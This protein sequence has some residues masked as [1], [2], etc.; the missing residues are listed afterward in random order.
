M[1]AP[2]A[3]REPRGAFF[4]PSLHA[5]RVVRY[6]C[7]ITPLAG[8]R[9]AHPAFRQSAD[10]KLTVPASLGPQQTSMTVIAAASGPRLHYPERRRQCDPLRRGVALK[11]PL[12]SRAYRRML[13]RRQIRQ[14][15]RQR[16]EQ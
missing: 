15:A 9:S 2:S 13:L 6:G 10:A 3:P 5:F 16:P 7:I 1:P 14:D 4:G 12:E 8:H 11:K